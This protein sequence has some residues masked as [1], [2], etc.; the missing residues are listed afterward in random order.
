MTPFDGLQHVGGPANGVGLGLS[1]LVGGFGGA[2]MTL[3]LENL[4]TCVKAAFYVRSWE[5]FSTYA[6]PRYRVSG[7]SDGSGGHRGLFKF[8]PRHEKRTFLVSFRFPSVV[9]MFVLRKSGL[10]RR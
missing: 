10:P 8:L 5:L 7:I 2:G 6:R 9:F 4:A 1:F 3:H